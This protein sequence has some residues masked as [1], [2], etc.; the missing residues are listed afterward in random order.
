M[1]LPSQTELLTETELTR[2]PYRR[3]E[4]FLIF[5][6]PLIEEDE[7][8]EVVATLRS[9]WIGRG[10]KTTKFEQEFSAYVQSEYAVAVN[11]CTAALHLALVSANIGAGDEV[12]IPAMTFC[13]TANAVIHSG[14]T[15][16][17]ID[18]DPHTRLIDI[19]CILSAITPK[20]K[21]IIP[22]H[23]AG[24]VCDMDEIDRIA[25]QHSLIVIEDAAHCIEGSYKNK[26]IGSISDFTCFS[27][28]ATK[29]LTTIEGG[30]LTTN[31][32]AFAERA[33]RLSLH[34]MDTDAWKRYSDSG[35]R[36]Y[37]VTD[38]GFK[39]N[40]TDVNASLG[41][42]QLRKIEKRYTLRQA[43]WDLYSRSLKDLP[44]ELPDKGDAE[45]RH[46]LHLYSPLVG[47]DSP[48]SRDKLVSALHKENIGTG[49]HYISL[50]LLTY[51]QQRYGYERG[52]CSVAEDISDRT[53]SLPLSY[54]MTLA[55]AEDVVRAMK[56]VLR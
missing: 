27:F 42:H 46:A 31:N 13:A 38:A 24:S 40:M 53:F 16:I 10:P 8:D 37:D 26:K 12:I 52:A 45:S 6:A 44:L 48:L 36:H 9:G 25:K 22:V 23:L 2:T 30:M 20:T 43:I 7:I 39:Y 18:C 4:T 50:T 5:G 55:D 11:S 3:R 49:I 14:A 56:H 19:K 28:Y 29:N 34:G 21:A 35:Y 32:L 1:T 15:P 51:Y 33:R 54:S 17:F 41:L 47:K